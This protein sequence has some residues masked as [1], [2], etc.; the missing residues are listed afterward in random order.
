MSVFTP[1]DV[2]AKLVALS[3]EYDSAHKDL[4]NAETAYAN[5]KSLWEINSARTRLRLRGRALEAGKKLTVQEV[6]DEATVAC[7]DE[8]TAL[9]AADA[10]I[11]AARA[12]AVRIRT[13]IDVARSVGTAV[14]AALDL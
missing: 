12:N 5:A 13:Q 4:D 6:E 14:R 8:L 1:A 11:R 9:N 7:A 2:E 10:L 3:R